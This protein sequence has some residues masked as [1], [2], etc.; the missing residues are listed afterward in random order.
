MN[1]QLGLAGLMLASMFL[2]LILIL[3]PVFV[4]CRVLAFMG[5]ASLRAH[6]AGEPRMRLD[7]ELQGLMQV[8]TP[9]YVYFFVHSVF[10]SSTVASRSEPV[11]S[12]AANRLSRHPLKAFRAQTLTCIAGLPSPVTGQGFR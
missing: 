1:G 8:T 3:V 2:R 12:F 5:D 4:V 11:C 7:R 9:A 6:V 10:T